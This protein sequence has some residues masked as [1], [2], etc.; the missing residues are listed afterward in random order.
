MK[1]ITSLFLCQELFSKF[2]SRKF[3][4]PPDS[5]VIPSVPPVR[6]RSAGTFISYH[7][8]QALS[9]TFFKFLKTFFS[10]LT[11]PIWLAAPVLLR[12]PRLF[13]LSAEPLGGALD[14]YTR[15][16]PLCQHLF[17]SFS[18]FFLPWTFSLHAGQM[19]L[20]CEHLS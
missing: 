5:V 4:H 13:S 2:F 17:S 20:C 12:A 1:Y 16:R 9:S 6:F 10:A 18:R 19:S 7:A 14:Y 11:G 3:S 15:P 8:V